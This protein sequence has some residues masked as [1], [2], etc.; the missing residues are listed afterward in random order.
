MKH[1]RDIKK[2]RLMQ[3]QP[4]VTPNNSNQP[5]FMALLKKLILLGVFL[6]LI[7]SATLYLLWDYMPARVQ[8][9]PRYIQTITAPKAEHAAHVPTPVAAVNPEEAL[10]NLDLASNTAQESVEEAE[11]GGA[12]ERS[13]EENDSAQAKEALAVAESAEVEEVQPTAEAAKEVEEVEEVEPSTN[14]ATTEE[15]AQVESA[16]SESE[17]EVE[18]AA[19]GEVADADADAEAEAKAEAEAETEAETEAEAES[20]ATTSNETS[21]AVEAGTSANN[22]ESAVTE[23]ALLP[24]PIHILPDS[25]AQLLGVRHEYQGWNNCGPS[26]LAMQL[27]FFGR[28]ETQNETAPFLKPDE[29]D[30]NVSPNEL[31][32][33]AHS[34]G[35]NGQVV[36]GGDLE[37]LRTFVANEFPVIVESWF[38]PDPDDEMGH[39][40]LFTGYDDETLTF[41][42]SYHGPDQKEDAHEFDYLWKVFNRTAIVVWPPE[43]EEL[44]Q[45]I[46]GEL[47]NTTVMHERALA[48]AHSEVKANPQDK[49]AWFNLG[50]NLTALGDIDNAVKAFD[51]ARSLELPWRMLW[52]Q[53]GPYQAYYENGQYDE[54]IALT[55]TTLESSYN[56]EESYY[57]RG[58]AK[59]A[60]GQ[61]EEARSD[62]E[63]AAGYNTNFAPAQEALSSLP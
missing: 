59:A 15:A 33:Y 44:A 41:F 47:A 35:Y 24:D 2:G 56:L 20:E 36:V 3:S 13:E 11:I 14:S 22:E 48:A 40:L 5:R 17:N 34:I 6:V 54:V 53:F 1:W 39:Y 19:A 38:I 37:L 23:A 58:K 4:V 63:E 18:T 25:S 16:S 28:S 52:Y 26:T 10:A 45:S 62:F 9:I 27:S 7:G 55:T 32:A 30:K 8:Y 31:L 57:W 12:V 51:T 21:E 61:N 50:T 49:Y 42:D 46:L 29:N 43:K 60:L